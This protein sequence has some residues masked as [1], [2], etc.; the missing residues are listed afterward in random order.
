MK[1]D[2][3]NEVIE[4]CFQNNLSEFKL[5]FE[6]AYNLRRKYF[7]D[8]I[9]FYAPGMVYFDTFFY[10]AVNPLRFP[11]LSITG[12]T[13]H[14]NCEHCRG[15]LLENM[16]PVENPD[17]LFKICLTIKEQGGKG[18]LISG[19]SLKDGSV[20][21]MKFIPAIKR[22]KE[23]L[24]LRMVIH[25]G[26][27]SPKMA[28]ALATV[29]VDGVML[30][31]IGS[32]ETI[33]KVYHLDR[34][35]EDFEYSLILLEQNGIPTIPHIV[36]GLHFGK[37]EGEKEAL[38]IVARRRIAALVIVVF[39]PLRGTPMEN[40]DPPPPIVVAKVMLAARFLMPNIP[41]LL[42]CA[43]PRGPYKASV[44]VLSIRAGVNGIAYPSGEAYDFATKLGL[45]VKIYDECCSLLWKEITNLN[46]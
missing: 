35:V 28:E 2:N 44:D 37:L 45:K 26:L 18:C 29:D 19:G 5:L 40:I 11:A 36:V 31:I 10:K 12:R 27:I 4:Q 42:G 33:R 25:T 20:P 8:V 3:I 17:D 23:E 7:S 6:K 30:D 43:C 13:C 15:K 14:L 1:I 22:V 24:G 34:T 39:M 21:L 38:K 41:L 32:N 16:I 46:K 9:Y